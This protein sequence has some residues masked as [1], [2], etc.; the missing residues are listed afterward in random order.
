MPDPEDPITLLAAAAV[1]LHE[2]YMAY[3]GAG[4]NENQALYLVG[5]ILSASVRGPGS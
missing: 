2:A 5:Q 4:F 3:V 1:Q